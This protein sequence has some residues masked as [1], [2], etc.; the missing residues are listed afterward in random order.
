[1]ERP[2]CLRI[3]HNV[4]AA[5]KIIIVAHLDLLFPKKTIKKLELSRKK[6]TFYANTVAFLCCYQSFHLTLAITRAPASTRTNSLMHA[7]NGMLYFSV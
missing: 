4:K 2:I 5:S 7:K 6:G 1:M 3:F